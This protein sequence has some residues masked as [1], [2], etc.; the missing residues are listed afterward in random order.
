MV[1]P[2]R[3]GFRRV[4]VKDGPGDGTVNS[5]SLEACENWKGK[6][7]NTIN[8]KQLENVQHFDIVTEPY[9]F[10]YLKEIL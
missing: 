10:Q 2:D 6:T 1:D 9:L 5:R 7:E 4:T 3:D 8:V